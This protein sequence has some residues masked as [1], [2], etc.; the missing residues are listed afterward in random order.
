MSALRFG[1]GAVQQNVQFYRGGLS[2]NI[3]HEIAALKPSPWPIWHFTSGMIADK[4][5]RESGR[6]L[7]DASNIVEMSSGGSG[8]AGGA[9]RHGEDFAA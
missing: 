1:L 7:Q 8:L 2:M 3:R 4:R 9:E 6:T 5:Q